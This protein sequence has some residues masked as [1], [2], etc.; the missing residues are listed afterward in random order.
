MSIQY[1]DENC[2][3]VG[4]V[5]ETF[6]IDGA[7]D[8]LEI[9]IDG[10][11]LQT[12]TLGHGGARTA[13]QVAAD[14]NAVLIGGTAYAVA[15]GPQANHVRIRTTSAAG[16]SSTILIG[17]PANNC[18][19]A[20][21]FTA[22]TYRGYT[23]RHT[24]WVQ[25]AG[26]KQEL[27]NK[28]ESELNACGWTTV[29]G[30][31]TTNLLM[32]S[33]LSPPGQNLQMRLRAKDN[34][35]NCVTLSIENVAGTKASTN[36]TTAGF[37]L[38]PAASKTW[39]FTVNKYQGFIRTPSVSSPRE[40]SGF[41]V[42]QV[43]SR[44][45]GVI[46]E[47]IWGGGNSVNDTDT[48][49]RACLRDRLRFGTANQAAIC[50]GN[51]WQRNNSTG[52]LGVGG[53]SLTAFS[54]SASTDGIFGYSWHDDSVMPFD[55]LIAWGL[56]ATSDVGKFRGL[57]WDAVISS[58]AYGAELTTSFDSHNWIVLTDNNTGTAGTY[59]Q[60]TLFLVTP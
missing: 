30:S 8:K 23:R 9:T 43:P 16:A 6:N 7:D 29:S 17:A 18:N 3:L 58:G 12:I 20:L 56:T 19:A 51:L 52:A 15:S 1:L 49:V 37:M 48:T 50:N 22:T 36:S 21:G 11:T 57:L 14:I 45:E 35:G 38:L 44:L 47:A 4:T 53:I 32:Q 31:G 2:D 54:C 27:I 59:V 10:G 25:S 33:A 46:T 5:A 24:S 28:I 34:A 55:A 26:T 42:P 13:I 39:L 41:G 60:G 40:F